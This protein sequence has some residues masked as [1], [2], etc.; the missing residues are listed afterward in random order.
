MENPLVKGAVLVGR[1]KQQVAILV[2]PVEDH[3]FDP[4]DEKKLSE[5]RNAIW[6]V[7]SGPLCHFQPFKQVSLY[8]TSIEAANHASPTFG[9][10]YKEYILTTTP[11]KP[12]PRTPKGTVSHKSATKL[13]ADEIEEIYAT[14]ERTTG[15]TGAPPVSW[16]EDD[17]TAW[18]KDTIEQLLERSVKIDTDIFDQGADRYDQ[19]DYRISSRY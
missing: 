3:E 8:R 4:S 7:L 16:T 10:I 18:I 12:L 5:F 9:R 14:V 11:G 13:Y 17:L 1:E 19:E 6:S 15:D 2:E